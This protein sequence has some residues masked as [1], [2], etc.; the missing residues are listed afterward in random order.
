M[1]A[2]QGGWAENRGVLGWLRESVLSDA[3]SGDVGLEYA[4]ELFEFLDE[5]VFEG[6]VEAV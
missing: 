4:G 5:L 1:G 3:A 6:D 2:A